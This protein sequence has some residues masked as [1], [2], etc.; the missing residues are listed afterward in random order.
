MRFS[1]VCGMAIV[2]LLGAGA[3][4]TGAPEVERMVSTSQSAAELLGGPLTT[5]GRSLI[6]GLP[7]IAFG[8][9]LKSLVEASRDDKPC[10]SSRTTLVSRGEG[11][12][13]RYL[14]TDVSIFRSEDGNS[15]EVRTTGVL[16][17]KFRPERLEWEIVQQRP[18]GEHRKMV[19]TLTIEEDE[20]V[21]VA[22][23]ETGKSIERRMPTPREDFVYLTGEMLRLLKLEAGQRFILNDLDTDTGKV[24]RRTFVVSKK[25]DK[26]LRVG[27][28]KLPNK[29]ESEYYEI[30][31]PGTI[32]RHGI[33]ELGLTFT[34]TTDARVTAIERAVRRQRR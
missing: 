1:A 19:E 31:E 30:A 10:A 7:P 27:I 33:H 6:E 9:N 8:T 18:S 12:D 23:D 20:M 22:T 16:T 34:A 32:L 11:Q 3:L 14:Y 2:T 15:I 21:K 5:L 24:I 4:V 29:V 13:I 26:R 25:D 28:R 17:Q